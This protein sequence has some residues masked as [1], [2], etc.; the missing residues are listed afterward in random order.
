MK[1]LVGRNKIIFFLLFSVGFIFFKKLSADNY[2]QICIGDNYLLTNATPTIQTI[3]AISSKEY[4]GKF[5]LIRGR[6]EFMAINNKVI[7]GYLSVRFFKEDELVD[8]AGNYDKEGFFIIRKDD[9]YIESGLDGQSFFKQM[10]KN[11]Q[12]KEFNFLKPEQITAVGE[13]KKQ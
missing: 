12:Q 11:Y 3:A 13:C 4:S 2:N 5:S 1:H 9:G 7:V 10:E 6:I 8:L